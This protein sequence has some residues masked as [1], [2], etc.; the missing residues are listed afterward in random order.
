MDSARLLPLGQHQRLKNAPG[1][2]TPVFKGK[3]EQQALVQSEVASKGFIPQE[4]V[5]NE[6]NWFY[7]GL[8]IDDTYFENEEQHVIAEHIIA[9]FGAK[10][11]AFTKHDPSTLV[12]DLEKIDEA[13]GRA[14]FI[15]TSS[16]GVTAAEGPGRDCE[17][18]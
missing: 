9:L 18:R 11:I 7:S 4:L 12:I 13:A 16:P 6:V 2:T 14:T 15:H 10:I 8:G 3:E 1:Y 17:L 5:P